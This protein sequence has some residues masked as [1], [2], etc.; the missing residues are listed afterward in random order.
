M[1]PQ[2]QTKLGFFP[3]P[4]AETGR[5]RN[6]L[7]FPERFSALDPCVGDGVAFTHLLHAVT[8]HRY[9]I[10]IDGE[11]RRTSASLRNRDFAGQRHGCPVP[12]R[13]RVLAL[14]EPSVRLG[15]R[16]EQQS[17]IGSC[18]PGTH[19]SLAQGWRGAGIRTAAA[20]ISEMREAAK[21]T[22]YGFASPGSPSQL[23]S[24]TS[25]S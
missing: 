4:V 14:S 1:R 7:R 15:I 8:A 21:R 23:A 17:E 16:R 6:W 22:F 25:R 18:L 9:G 11:S 20:A 12:A 24:N 5:L 3:L 13:S 2:G 10:E 19:I